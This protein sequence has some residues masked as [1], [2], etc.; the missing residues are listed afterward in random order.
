MWAMVVN[1]DEEPFFRYFDCFEPTINHQKSLLKQFVAKPRKNMDNLTDATSDKLIF[2]NS[3]AHIQKNIWCI[4]DSFFFL[5]FS[6]IQETHIENVYVNHSYI[7]CNR[8]GLFKATLFFFSP[9]PPSLYHQY[10]VHFILCNAR[11]YMCVLHWSSPQSEPVAI[12]QNGLPSCH[13]LSGPSTISQCIYDHSP[14]QL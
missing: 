1:M 3:V 4:L 13:Q 14:L 10:Y 7:N 12:H 8:I 5:F 9:G 6:I 11:M 2:D